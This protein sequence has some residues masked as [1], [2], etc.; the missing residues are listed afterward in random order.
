MDLRDDQATAL[1]LFGLVN[2]I[3]ERMISHPKQVLAVYELLP[4]EKRDAIDKRNAKG[5]GQKKE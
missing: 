1:K 4:P 5:L 2:M 3:V